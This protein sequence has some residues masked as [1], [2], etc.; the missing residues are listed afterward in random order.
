MANDEAARPSDNVPADTDRISSVPQE[1]HTE[2]S[3]IQ[4]P[5]IVSEANEHIVLE[6]AAPTET[7]AEAPTNE[8]D[9][10]EPSA[11]AWDEGSVMGTI[12]LNENGR[13]DKT[14]LPSTNRKDPLNMSFWRKWAGILAMGLR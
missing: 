9:N 2:S 8:N 12:P 3:T 14:P 1:S 4:S 10:T 6:A 13:L 5:A 7:D 11:S